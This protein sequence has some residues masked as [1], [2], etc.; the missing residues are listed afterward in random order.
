[1]ASVALSVLAEEIETDAAAIATEIG[2]GRTTAQVQAL[3]EFLRVLGRR[4]DLSVPALLLLPP[5]DAA[6]IGPN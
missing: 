4:N 3:A 2:G 1:M 5:A 6:G